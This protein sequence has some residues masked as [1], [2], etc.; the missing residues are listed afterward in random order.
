MRAFT[1]VSVSGKPS[2]V[3]DTIYTE[4]Q[5]ELI[6]HLPA[7]SAV[8]VLDVGSSQ[9][10]TSFRS[11]SAGG[12]RRRDRATRAAGHR[13]RDRRTQPRAAAPPGPGPAEGQPHVHR[14]IPGVVGLCPVVPFVLAA[15]S[16]ANKKARIARAIFADPAAWAKAA[17]RGDGARGK[18]LGHM[19][20]RRTA[21]HLCSHMGRIPAGR[22]ADPGG[23]FGR[24]V[25][26][27]G[28]VG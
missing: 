20:D 22:S 21:P 3:F 17:G 27:R 7:G 19:M 12:R 11:V 26:R 28:L 15:Q 24:R 2:L 6:S 5:Q 1:G 13:R 18:S 4:A 16:A 14:S 8:R 9:V 10:G 25:C 23:Q